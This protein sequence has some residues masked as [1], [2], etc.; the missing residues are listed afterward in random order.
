MDGITGLNNATKDDIDSLLINESASNIPHSP[1]DI[2]RSSMTSAPLLL[3][4][5]LY[6]QPASASATAYQLATPAPR[7]NSEPY[8]RAA[9]YALAK[10]TAINMTISRCTNVTHPLQ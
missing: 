9:A 2:V 8:R 10:T 1:I 4:Q 3:E 6:P 5:P 7:P